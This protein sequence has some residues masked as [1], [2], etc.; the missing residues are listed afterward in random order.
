MRWDDTKID[1]GL[2]R[3]WNYPQGIKIEE[4]AK[5]EFKV[6]ITIHRDVKGWLPYAA[7]ETAMPGSI[8]YEYS[9]LKAY[10]EKNYPYDADPVVA[11]PASEPSVEEQKGKPKSPRRFIAKPPPTA[12]SDD[13]SEKEKKTSRFKKK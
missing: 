2:V 7:A 4:V 6:T 13:K 5:R 11:E 1:N 8:T 3:G 9:A 10:V 12:P